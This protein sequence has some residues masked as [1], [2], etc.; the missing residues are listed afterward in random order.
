MLKVELHAHTDRDP[1]DRIAHSTRQ[2]ID[3]AAASG[4]QALAITLHDT[5]FDPA[6]D[7]GYARERGVVLI[8]GIERSIHHRHVLLLNFPASCAAVRDF[9]DIAELKRHSPG[10]LVIAPHPFYPIAS[11][12]RGQLQRHAALFDAVEVNS[13]YTRL[14]NFNRRAI[15]WARATGKPL[16]GSTDL[17]VLD[18]LGTT[19]TLVAAEAD[20]DAICEAIRAG[21]T[22][23]RTRPLSTARA[24][25]IFARMSVAG[26]RGRLGAL[27]GGTRQRRGHGDQAWPP[28]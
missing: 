15:Q 25:W 17:H 8:A 19:S 24:G 5:Y 1:L 28:G 13:M 11:A 7:D 27:A 12:L 18:Q 22:E 4:Y 2:L 9:A 20:A 23:V 16:V 26:L 10:G 21:R 6:D 14:V 3:R